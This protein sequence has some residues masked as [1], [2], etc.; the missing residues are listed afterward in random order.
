M[1][2]FNNNRTVFRILIFLVLINITALAT[3]FIYIRKAANE[4][5]PA[6]RFNQGIALREELSLTPEQSLKVNKINAT[7]KASSEPVVAA[8]KEKKAILLDELTKNDTDTSLVAKLAEDVVLEQK[9]LQSANIKQFLDLKKICTPEQTKK[10]S[11]IY[12]ELYGCENKGLGNGKGKGQG[13]GM[14]HRYGQQNPK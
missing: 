8:I 1:N 14:R 2:V 12:S 10:L 7:Y 11:H 13:K 3:Y 9:N 4:P 5:V 6:S